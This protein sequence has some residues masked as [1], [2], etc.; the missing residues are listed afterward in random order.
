MVRLRTLSFL[1]M[2]RDQWKSLAELEVL[3]TRRLRRLV[4]EAAGV[5]FYAQLFRDI[6]L[7]A[8]DIRSPADLRQI[9][10]TTKEQLQNAGLDEITSRRIDLSRCVA[11]GTS[12]STGIPLRLFFTRAD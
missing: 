7:R 4:R 1:E 6:K 8:E 2:M 9:P 3:Q 11:V 12:G 10:I 5:P